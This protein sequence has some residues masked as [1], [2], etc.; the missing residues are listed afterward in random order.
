MDS[1]D[2]EEP[3]HNVVEGEDAE[4]LGE[5]PM[6]LKVYKQRW[7]ILFIF[8]CVSF[9]NG[10]LYTCIVSINDIIARYYRVKEDRVDWAG[11]IFPFMYIFM[12]LP[13]AYMMTSLG[14]RTLVII[15]SS[16]NA[17]GTCL[18]FA[19]VFGNGYRFIM[20]GQVAAALSFPTIL[21]VP[22]RLSTVWFP[23]YEHAKATSIA[24]VAN[25]F[26]LGIGFLQPSYMVP[27]VETKEDIYAGLYDL[28]LTHLIFLIVCL[29]LVYSFF[30][31]KP[32]LPPSF[33]A[34]VSK[35][36][37]EDDD[38]VEKEGESPTMI[39]SIKVLT[40]NKNFLILTQAYALYFGLYLFYVTCLN[41]M[42]SHL[43]EEIYIGWM[44]FSADVAAIIGILVCSVI[45]DKF[46]AYQICS[47]VLT[48]GVLVSWTLFALSVVRWKSTI[49][50]FVT[51]AMVS[52][53]GAPF[54]VVGI[55]YTAE[56]TYPISE[57]LSSA[58]ILL[59]GNLYGFLMVL[60]FGSW[61][62]KGHLGFATYF[63][64]GVYAV[65]FILVCFLRQTLNR[66]DAE[67]HHKRPQTTNGEE[68]DPLLI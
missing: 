18:H 33:A 8:S 43:V 31:E 17:I 36:R 59:L 28:Y 35:F 24:M 14:L 16:L 63:V 32:P 9:A 52:L 5:K 49:A 62:E 25:V 64:I 20:G 27:D 34:A 42:V 15:G 3:L 37:T 21:Q 53:F 61:I 26:G 1:D 29:G 67:R 47:L 12:A 19:G 54:F 2:S 38:S 40:V 11:N 60:F 10:V 58:I 48:F 7:F 68:N 66:H 22:V 45:I 13:S 30:K 65:C 6:K 4:P 46:Q 23:E 57:G 41:D 51:Y 39:Q 56:V 55:E 44:G 50:L